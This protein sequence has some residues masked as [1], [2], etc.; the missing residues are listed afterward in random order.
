MRYVN[1]FDEMDRLRKEV[2]KSEAYIDDKVD[3]NRLVEKFGDFKR[4]SDTVDDY[5][6]EIVEEAEMSDGDA[7][8]VETTDFDASADFNE[9][10]TS[11]YKGFVNDYQYFDLRK[12]CSDF[13]ITK[14]VFDK[15]V[16]Y[17]ADRKIVLRNVSSGYYENQYNQKKMF[18]KVTGVY[19]HYKHFSDE[20]V[21]IVNKD[22]ILD[23]S[24]SVDISCN[25][26]NSQ[27][28]FGK[29]F[30]Y[31]NDRQVVNPCIHTIA[32]VLLLYE[33]LKTHSIG[34]ETDLAGMSFINLLESY[35]SSFDNRDG[36]SELGENRCIVLSPRI[37]YDKEF[38]LDFRIGKERLF[39]LK[40]FSELISAYDE[41]K[42]Y[43]LGK[44]DY[45]DFSKEK[46]DD[47]SY[48]YFKLLRNYYE[49]TRQ[50]YIYN[51]EIGFDERLR[52]R[53]IPLFGR[54]LDD[55]YDLVCEKEIDGEIKK[56][57]K[58]KTGK[59]KFDN[60]DFKAVI[61]LDSKYDEDRFV[62]L[63][64]EISMP[65]FMK[66]VANFYF[67]EDFLFHRVS[68]K[69]TVELLPITEVLNH[70]SYRSVS[71]RTM[72]IGRN[73]LRDFYYKILPKLG[74]AVTI[75]EN[76]SDE[77]W[78]YMPPEGNYKFFLDTNEDFILCEAIVDYEGE[79]FYLRLDG[80]EKGSGGSF[81][82]FKKEHKIVELLNKY[83][84]YYDSDRSEFF[85]D[86]NADT[87]YEILSFGLNELM[88]EGEV[89]VSNAFRRLKIRHKWGINVGV[90]V[91]SEIMTV[92]LISDEIPEDELL[93]ILKSYRKKKKYHKLK[94][95]ELID[96]QTDSAQNLNELMEAMHVS[97]KDFVAG[98]IQIPA[99]RALYLNKMLEEHDEIAT[100]R[101][102][103]FKTLI[104]NFKTVNDSDFNLPDSLNKI[105]RKYQR[106]G[107]RWLMTL[108]TVGF[109][110]ILADEMGLGKTLQTISMFLYEKERG[111]EGTSLVVCPASLV[112]NWG[113]ELE[114][115]APSLK[116]VLITGSKAERK[117]LIDSI[118]DYDV[119]VTSYD[120]L[121]RDIDLYEKFHFNYQIVDE[122]QYIKNPKTDAAKAVKI[123]NS[124]HRFALTGTP[125]ENKLSELWSIFDYLMPGFLYGYEEFR[126]EFETPIIK[127]KS[128]NA[129]LKLKKMVS[130]FILR[131][132]KKDML[133]D[134]PDKITETRHTNFENVQR[135]L[136]DA[137]VAH[138]KLTLSK[139]SEEDY[140]KM[141]LQILSE[142]TRLRQICCDPSLY[143]EDYK[144]G[145]AKKEL[146][147][148]MI[149]D[150]IEGGHKM[151]VFSQF[152]SMLSIIEKELEKNDIKYY[153]I[154]GSTPTK[155]RLRLVNEFNEN[156]VPVFLISLKAGGT[157]LNLVGAD[158][159]IHYD[160]WWN[161]AV[162]NQA[163]DRTHRIGQKNVVT[164]YKLI[165][166]GT[167]EEKI[168][169]MQE[170]KKN[171]ADEILKGEGTSL[172]SMTKEELL[173]LL[174]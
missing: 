168:V 88:D 147:M 127:R 46:F 57:N 31:G 80:G 116:K 141:K 72:M 65:D 70:N 146:L 122:A 36:I 39:I 33:Y 52:M 89:N 90:S 106:H 60:K 99:Y 172:S 138:M 92:D 32:V 142:L 21:V 105:M 120:L 132:L 53:D 98:K 38:V 1:I 37:K 41:R 167:I 134:L 11:K 162:Q 155:E 3:R 83:F 114:K 9:N 157:G 26:T 131:R 16:N 12:I 69:R 148:E 173:E 13:R 101:D 50:R 56:D 40:S 103:T 165:V 115:Y 68:K 144:G 22:S 49:E 87:I 86:R 156:E 28:I 161:V 174:S 143:V 121:K 158:I 159:V 170:T 153:V 77:F 19:N 145:S 25:Y 169:K 152:T 42:V 20:I 78:D 130:P 61:T 64:C 6:T 136:Y 43:R 79:E 15:A 107:F 54:F 67:V 63:E 51:E 110:G 93:D 113:E 140:N 75:V 171:L 118:S 27:Y 151:L 23:I 47:E 44:N 104:K 163:T 5:E 35:S 45:L 55:F 29:A 109:G 117:R 66:G 18:C 96:L 74:N 129:S 48:E 108:S 95:G 139:S 82:D 135:K 85:C 137:S 73:H 14:E 154:T 126:N 7:S 111:T 133:K 8:G 24:C 119:C 94:S 81:R 128:E 62:G 102:K 10:K 123:I 97:L 149:S 150:A 100:E 34:D 166:K 17:V 125:I 160:P 112:Y 4:I 59:F 124:A 30:S 76:Q 91:D 58:K 164:E 84:N 2:E 71:H